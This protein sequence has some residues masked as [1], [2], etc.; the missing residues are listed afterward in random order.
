MMQQ[1]VDKLIIEQS[2]AS[3]GKRFLNF[4]IDNIVRAILVFTILISVMAL[5]EI[6]TGT[7]NV[8][9]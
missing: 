7:Q 8:I 5:E 6:I 1:K 9:Y 2:L 4:I 3:T